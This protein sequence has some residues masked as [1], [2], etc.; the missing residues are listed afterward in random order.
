MKD[1]TVW[2]GVIVIVAIIVLT[3]WASW[4]AVNCWID[5]GVWVKPTVGLPT[6]LE[7]K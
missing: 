7:P 3:I 2:V 5:G 1:L 6:C 4:G